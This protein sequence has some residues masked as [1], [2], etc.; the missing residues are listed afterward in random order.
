M[1]FYLKKNLDYPMA[2]SCG[3]DI[4]QTVAPGRSGTQTLETIGSPDLI[5]SSPS[6]VGELM[7]TTWSWDTEHNL[8]QNDDVIGSEDTGA[9]IFD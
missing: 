3:A 4:V 6:L 9:I 1:Y 8:A 5:C 2:Y 7:K